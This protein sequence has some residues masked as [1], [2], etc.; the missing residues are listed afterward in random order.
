MGVVVEVERVFVYDRLHELKAKSNEANTK[1]QTWL[2]ID[3]DSNDDA[4]LCSY[5]LLLSECPLPSILLLYYYSS[6]VSN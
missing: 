5:H 6:S 3:V 1:L 4:K 2:C